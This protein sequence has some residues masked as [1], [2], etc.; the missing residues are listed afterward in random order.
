[1]N[2]FANAQSVG[3]I[4]DQLA[5]TVVGDRADAGQPQQIAAEG[6]ERLVQLGV[7]NFG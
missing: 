2:R 4:I 6:K 1:M 5:G 7:A 3:D